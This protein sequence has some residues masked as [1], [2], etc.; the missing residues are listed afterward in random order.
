MSNKRCYSWAFT[1]CCQ[2]PALVYEYMW[3]LKSVN[4]NLFT[5]DQ[6]KLVSLCCTGKVPKKLED[7]KDSFCAEEYSQICQ[8]L[9]KNS[10]PGFFIETPHCDEYL[11][12]REYRDRLS[13][14]GKDKYM[15][16][17]HHHKDKEGN[18]EIMNIDVERIIIKQNIGLN[19]ISY[20]DEKKCICME[21]T[22][23]CHSDTKILECLHC[24][25]FYDS[26]C[27][28]NRPFQKCCPCGK[29]Y[30]RIYAEN[31]YI[32]HEICMAC[33]EKKIV[34]QALECSHSFCYDC[35]NLFKE[36]LGKLHSKFKIYRSSDNKDIQCRGFYCYKCGKIKALSIFI[37]LKHK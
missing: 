8:M 5:N 16:F 7:Y 36:G 19:G 12:P 20:I 18:V 9:V 10:E 3:A 22:K 31:P 17:K 14:C 28:I 35:F 23:E 25:Q 2:I 33:G 37:L 11:T 30:E 27:I 24:G 15:N 21:C 32:E 29:L 1:K 34:F 13:K 6:E 26:N 4:T